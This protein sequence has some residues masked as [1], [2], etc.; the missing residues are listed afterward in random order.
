VKKLTI[1]YFCCMHILFNSR[2]RFLPVNA[3]FFNFRISAHWVTGNSFPILQDQNVRLRYRAAIALANLQDS[4]TV[5]ALAIAL[6]DSNK[7]VRAASALALGQIKT[8]QSS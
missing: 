3:K 5:K 1:D 4:S 7:D 6:K 2:N 8:E